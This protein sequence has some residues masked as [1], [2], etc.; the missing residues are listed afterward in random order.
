M[1]SVIEVYC[2]IA[3]RN[4]VWTPEEEKKAIH[5]LYDKKNNAKFVNE[6]MKHNLWL[7][8]KLMDKY[9]FNKFNEDV[10]QGAVIGLT[11]ALKSYDPSKGV[12]IS[13]W[14]FEPIKWAILKYQDA[15]SRQGTISDE[16]MSF[17]KKYDINIS[18]VELDRRI[19]GYE[20]ETNEDII[21]E[22]TIDCDY[23]RINKI[24]TFD[25]K[26]RDSDISIGILDLISGKYG[27]ILN[28]REAFVI[29]NMA[30]GMNQTEIS[31]KMKLSKV[32]VSQIV[33]GAF[34]KIRKSN[35][36]KHLRNLIN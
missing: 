24:R 36:G 30:S 14:V 18:V 23:I 28:D 3:N 1:K 7:V 17:N 27:K 26:T 16:M 29:K 19:D 11:N 35:V 5:R 12:K 34:E 2:D 10:F 32:R 33:A 31:K 9:S 25:E 13:T 21:T 4:P 20:N 15:Y 8:F 6:A 22:K